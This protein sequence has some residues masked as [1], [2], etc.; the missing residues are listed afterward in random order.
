MQTLTNDLKKNSLA[1]IIG[2][3]VGRLEVD[4]EG[5]MLLEGDWGVCQDSILCV[6]VSFLTRVGG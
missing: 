2:V 3:V 4:G 5:F 6:V 1:K